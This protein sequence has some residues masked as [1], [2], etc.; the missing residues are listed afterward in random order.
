MSWKQ[1]L[2]TVAPAIATA[3]GTPLAGIAV[4]LACEKLGLSEH[5]EAALASAVSGANPEQLVKIKEAD[6]QLRIDLKKLDIRLDEIA[7]EDR[8]SARHLAE[9]KGILV[10]ALLTF[11]LTFAFAWILFALFEGKT[12]LDDR[13][14]DIAFYAM[15]TLNG[16]LI[17][18]WNFWFGTS[19]GSKDKGEQMERLTRGRGA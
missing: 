17:Q 15:G 5:T 7:A 11:M 12:G 18:A 13:T 9:V 10:Q 14:E 2:A 19:K 1:T 16:L 3:L 4:S 6:A 8:A